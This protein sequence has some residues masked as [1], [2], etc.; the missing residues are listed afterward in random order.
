MIKIMNAAVCFFKTDYPKQ[1]KNEYPYNS[2][3]MHEEIKVARLSC[4]ILLFFDCNKA[5]RR[6]VL[7]CLSEHSRLMLCFWCLAKK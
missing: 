2:L 1:T 4:T 7:C 3:H 5:H 6:L